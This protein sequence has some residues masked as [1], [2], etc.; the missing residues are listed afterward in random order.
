PALVDRLVAD[1]VPLTVCPM[2]NLALG[3]VSRLEDHNLARLLRRGVKV[4]INSDDPAYFGGYVADNYLATA[5]ALDLSRDDL[6]TMARNSIEAS[7]APAE[8]RAGWRSEL[9]HYVATA[10]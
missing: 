6:V 7:F 1:Q 4:T 3:G 5:T 2:S 10:G 9:D 8:Q